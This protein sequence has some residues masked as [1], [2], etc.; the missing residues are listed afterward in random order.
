M[1]SFM[2]VSQQRL[3]RWGDFVRVRLGMS[4]SSRVEIKC[5]WCSILDKMLIVDLKRNMNA[6]LVSTL[7]R[8]FW[9]S[10]FIIIECFSCVRLVL[11]RYLTDYAPT[12]ILLYFLETDILS[13]LATIT[14]SY[15]LFLL[16]K[17]RVKHLCFTRVSMGLTDRLITA[18]IFTL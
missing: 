7:W 13:P 16:K 5:L 18:E 2:M 17:G 14:L 11:A 15:S 6:Q 12:F 10:S 3:V 8:F 4:L 9:W 1:W